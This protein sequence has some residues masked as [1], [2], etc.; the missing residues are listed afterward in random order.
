MASWKMKRRQAVLLSVLKRG[1]REH[2]HAEHPIRTYKKVNRQAPA[3]DLKRS[4]SRSGRRIRVKYRS[5]LDRKTI[6]N[7]HMVRA[8]KCESERYS[9]L[10]YTPAYL[11]HGHC[12]RRAGSKTAHA[13]AR[14]KSIIGQHM[15]LLGRA[16]PTHYKR[17]EKYTS[18]R[19]SR[20]LIG[21]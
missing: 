2:S 4:Y 21:L 15:P 6:L 17:V 19:R 9:D 1:D 11:R 10:I 7:T 5:L 12:K 8:T 14:S 3:C 13:L 18:V 16:I 20:G